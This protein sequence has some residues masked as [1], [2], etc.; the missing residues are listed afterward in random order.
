[1][2]DTNSTVSASGRLGQ[3]T[4][5][6]V[7][8]RVGV[9]QTL[10]SLVLRNAP[11]ASAETRE[12]V[13]RAAADLGY[14]PD[15]AAQVLRRTRSRHIGVLFTMRQPFDVDLVEAIYPA[16]ERRGYHVVLG[17]I[18]AGRND[19]Q[20]VEELLAF[21]SE[22]LILD[23]TSIKAAQLARVADQMPVV[24]I[25]R[26]ATGD[27]V[28]VV[29]VADERGARLATDHLIS[30]GHHSIVHIDGG[31]QPAA[32][33]RRRGY[34]RAM[35]RHGLQHEI[36]VLPGDYTEESGATAARRIL[37]EGRFPT[38]IFAANDRCAHGVLGTLTHAGVDVPGDISVMG[39]D[40]SEVA[41]L[42]FINL[43]T[44]HQ[45]ATLMAEQAVQAVIERLDEGRTKARDIV[46]DPSL[47]V[48]GTTGP[49][50]SGSASGRP[51]GSGLAH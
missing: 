37:N 13:L 36:R 34:Q 45:D 27:S 21:R 28:D 22:A 26:R 46:L 33:E 9:S 39:Y 31:G 51:G 49:P 17:A 20:A 24:D 7:A 40:D 43:T 50:R 42:S 4:M 48:R 12:R 2:T 15:I 8:A 18:G 30:L 19:R 11:G 29:R 41:R 44:I 16:A 23:G 6:D 32:A 25:G 3:P 38:A 47:M 35:R 10:V 5:R 14:R 1:M